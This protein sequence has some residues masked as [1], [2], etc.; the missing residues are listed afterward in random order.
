MAL[1]ASEAQ[2]ETLEQLS[3]LMSLLEGHGDVIMDRAGEGLVPSA[4]RFGRV[5]RR[6][7]ESVRGF[8]KV[9]QRLIGLDAKIKQYAEGERFIESVEAVGGTALLDRVWE[10]PGNVPGIAEIR[11]PHDWVSRMSVTDAA[12]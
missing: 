11:N 5:M 12:A 3:G 7:R 4:P 9:F 6:R 1:F 2:V 10:A 8:A